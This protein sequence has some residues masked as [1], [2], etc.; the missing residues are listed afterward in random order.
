MQ[1]STGPLPSKEWTTKPLEMPSLECHQLNS[2]CGDNNRLFNI[3]H[4]ELLSG[5]YPLYTCRMRYLGIDYGSKRVGVAISDET[6][7]FANPLVVLKNSSSLL[8][9]IVRICKE[10]EV[11][12]V[13]VGESKNFKQ[14]DNVIMSEIKPF[15]ENLKNVGLIVFLEPEFLTSQEAEHIQGEGDMHDA[16][17]AAIILNSYL[18]KNK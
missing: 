18:N 2:S 13:V 7:T 6:K 17:A 12:V 8:D 10:K 1:T 15:V 11:E 3:C 16:S 5:R 4:L 14:E 9:E